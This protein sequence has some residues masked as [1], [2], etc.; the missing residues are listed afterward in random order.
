[1]FRSYGPVTTSRFDHHLPPPRVQ[2]RE[3]LYAA[4]HIDTTLAEAFQDTRVIDRRAH[5]PWL[6]G[7]R[8]DRS[9]SLL[10]LTGA[11]PT[12]AGASMAI[13]SG[14]RDR[15]RRWSRAIYDAYPL[16][17]GLWYASSMHANRP[18]VAL[19]E[20]ALAVLPGHPEFHRPLVDPALMIMLRNAAHKLGYGLV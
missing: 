7:F 11:W 13:N 5:E 2:N 1:M 17:E 14:R 4:K 3:I 20:R 19:N 16:V 10:D 15:A 6:V 12:R 18:A 8:L 9:V